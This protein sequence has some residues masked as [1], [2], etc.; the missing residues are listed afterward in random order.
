V[1]I[2]REERTS[3]VIPRVDGFLQPMHAVVKRVEA[4]ELRQVDPAQLTL[5]NVNTPDDVAR[6]DHSPTDRG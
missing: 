2:Q 5:F 6:A 3:I 1:R 4:A